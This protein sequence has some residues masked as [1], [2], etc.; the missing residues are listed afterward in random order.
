MARF[1]FITGGVVSSLGKGIAAASLGALLQ[2]RGYACG[3]ASS[4]P[5]ST[6]IRG[7]EPLPHGEV[8]V[9]DDGAEADPR[10]RPLRALHRRAR[11][12]G[13][14]LDHRA[15]VFEVI[16]KE[17]RGDYLGATVQVIPHITDAI[18]EAVQ[19]DTDAYDF[20]LVEIGG[21]VGDIECC[22]SWRRSASSPTSWGRRAPVMHLTLVP[23]ISSAGELKTKPDAAFGEG[24]AGRGHPAADPAVPLRPADPGER[25][26]QDRA[27]LQRPP[28]S[29]IPAYD[30]RSIYAVPLSYHRRAG[31]RGAAPLQPQHLRR[32][33]HA[34]VAAGGRAHH[35]PEGESPSPWW[36][37]TR[38]CSTPTS[39]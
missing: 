37:S 6:W 12:A 20:V 10:P 38:A 2:A 4:T 28:E 21:T 25:A 17:R 31:P 27:V 29:V 9:T 7:H 19:A 5:I 16:A 22:P 26:P 24:A 18:K 8:F 14:Q 30:A 35:Q 1:V 11:D 33:R 15:P 23:Y 13:R 34:S 36:A 32:A 39:R 3:C